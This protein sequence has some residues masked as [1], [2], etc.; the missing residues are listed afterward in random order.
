MPVTAAQVVWQF[1]GVRPLY[2][3]G[4]ADPSA[5]SR[6]YVLQLEHGPAP[7]LSVFGG[8]LTTYRSLAEKVLEKLAPT[9]PL[10][11]LPWTATAFP[12]R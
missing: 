10:A 7:L 5:V 12:T 8:K 1:A 3:D 11:D 4:R 2:D 9:F 6:E